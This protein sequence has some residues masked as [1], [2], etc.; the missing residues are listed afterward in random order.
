[1]KFAS[2]TTLPEATK[3][4]L[5][6][7]G[8]LVG[9]KQQGNDIAFKTLALLQNIPKL[10]NPAATFKRHQLVRTFLTPG[11]EENLWFGSAPSPDP[12]SFLWPKVLFITHAGI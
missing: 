5:A 11:D 9:S 1:M 12:K 6:W 10:F 7:T 4:G 3:S 2:F 8:R